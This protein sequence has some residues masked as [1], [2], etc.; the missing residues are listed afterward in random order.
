MRHCDV[1]VI[2][3]S[4]LSNLG[5]LLRRYLLDLAFHFSGGPPGLE[6]LNNFRAR[7]RNVLRILLN[8]DPFDVLADYEAPK[9]TPTALT[10]LGSLFLPL[11]GLIDLSAERER[12]KKE[13]AKVEDEL[14]KVRAKLGNPNFAGKVPPAVLEEHRQREAAWA[15]KLAQLQRMS[16]G[17]GE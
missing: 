4:D 16:E 3:I 13:I 9:G 10:P 5:H 17:L 8:A 15:E 14:G 7:C 11:E 2:E 12:L 1:S 6:E